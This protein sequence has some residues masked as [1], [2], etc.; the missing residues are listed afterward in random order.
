ARECRLLADS[1]CFDAEWYL[2]NHPDVAQAGMDPLYH[3]CKYGWPTL[4]NPSADFD[5]WWYW[6]THLDPA[7]ES[8]N[9]LVHYVLTGRQAGLATRPAPYVL[10]A[11]GHELPR[12]RAVRRACLF[13]G[14]DPD[15]LI[16]DTAV[17]YVREL[18]RHADVWYLADGGMRPGELDKLAGITQGAWAQ[19]HGAY[20]FGSWSMLARDLVGWDTLRQYDEVLLVN[21]SGYLL[22]TLDDVFARMD[23][24]PCD[25]WGLQATK[26]VFATRYKP[27][28]QFREPIPIDA[29]KRTWLPRYE[30]EYP[31]DF[32][33]GSY[34]LGLRRP[35][36]DDA[37]FRRL[38]DA[39][40][41]P[42]RKA[43][44]IGKSRIGLGRY[45]MASGHPFD[46]YIERRCPFHPIISESACPL[47]GKGFPLLKR[48]LLAE[49]HYQSGGLGH[50]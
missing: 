27:A 14:Y 7:S 50:W 49:N 23:A 47:I 2:R 43:N 38:L 40:T 4:R 9:P 30:T 28:N 10:D 5:V 42:S 32:L 41:M 22:R 35:V 29:V 20:D 48:Y 11:P 19:R 26:G 46:T 37:G 16:D 13:A 45:L 33:I 36:L 6:S 21:D 3:F 34:F 1:G 12:D 44:V 24:R 18:S 31:Y 25:W 17:A 15:G 8:T 39:V